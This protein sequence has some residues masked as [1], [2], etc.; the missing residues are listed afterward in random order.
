MDFG[1]V[2][3]N[4]QYCEQP[5]EHDERVISFEGKVFHECECFTDYMIENVADEPPLTYLEYLEKR[6]LEG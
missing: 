6:I 2:F 4:C 5:F 1:G 3:M